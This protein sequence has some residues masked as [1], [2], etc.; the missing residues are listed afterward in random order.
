MTDQL[1]PALRTR[2]DRLAQ[3]VPVGTERLLPIASVAPRYRGRSGLGLLAA[4]GLVLVLAL[5]AASMGGG[6]NTP[7]TLPSTT[8]D[9]ASPPAP[10][11]L[12]VVRIPTWPDPPPASGACPLAHLG[13][14]TLRGD[15]AGLSRPV[16]VQRIDGGQQL[17][18]VWPY[19]F[20]ARFNPDLELLNAEGEVVAR[21]GDV[22]DLGG[23]VVS[24]LDPAYDFYACHVSLAW[25]PLAVIQPQDG[26]DMA[27]AEGTL[28]ITDTCVVLETSGEVM[29]LFWPADRTRWNG[30]KRTITFEN[31]DGSVITVADGDHVVLGGGGDSSAEGG[32]SGAEWVKRMEWVRPPASSCPLD[33][34]F[35]VGGVEGD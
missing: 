26:T 35:G 9:L 23:G 16:W 31:L 21:E 8:P 19:G 5:A 14:V 13:R 7:D 4:A 30:E 24:S 25:G 33:P 17:D 11:A 12:P 22:L 29:L 3:A 2:L 10:S 20:T 28:R 27:R 1:D 34:R 32:I 6:T 18:I 15:P